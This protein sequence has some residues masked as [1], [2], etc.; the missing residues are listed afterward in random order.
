[1]YEDNEF[2]AGRILRNQVDAQGKALDATI[3]QARTVLDANRICL[4]R[5]FPTDPDTYLAFL[6]GFG[7]PLANYSSRSDLAKD[8]PHPQINR[9]KYKPKGEYVKHSVHYVGGELSP[10]SAR[11]WCTPRPAFFAMLMV[12]PGWRDTPEGERGES[13]VLS[14][15]HLFK[16]LAA[17]D[18]ELFAEHFARLTGTPIRF[19]ANNVR[20]ELSDLPLCYPLADSTSPYDVGVRLKQD[21]PDKLRDQP[22]EI[23]D[24]GRYQRALD[25]LVS[26][27]AEEKLQACFPMD[28]GHLLLLDNNRFAH[29]RRKIIGQRTVDDAS[30]VNPRELWSVTVA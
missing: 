7:T 24:F 3:A 23:P 20:E 22:G 5:N 11:S 9:V 27:A 13:V 8:A 19:E 28:S 17:R 18:G 12:D 25:Y 30:Q 2:S 1:M 26:N 29:G 4:V 14:W 21:L 16:Q 15:R 10:H 6:G